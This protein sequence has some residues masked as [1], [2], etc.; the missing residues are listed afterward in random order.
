MTLENIEPVFI[1][2]LLV[3]IVTISMVLILLLYYYHT[4]KQRKYDEK[5][6]RAEL[7]M[8]RHELEKQIYQVTNRLLATEERWKDIHHLLISAQNKMLSEDQREYSV[9]LTEFLKAAGIKE[10][11]LMIKKDRVLVLTPFHQDFDDTYEVITSVCRDVGLTCFRGDEQY[12][13]SDILP[14]ILKLMVQARIII[15]NI[16]GR[17]PNVSYELGLAHAIDKPTIL[18]TKGIGN[19]RGAVELPI[20]LKSRKI[21]LYQNHSDLAEALRA[22]ITRVLVSLE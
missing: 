8:L 4:A 21:I 17:N 3:V 10:Q 2:T 18:L 1:I 15:A 16:E 6:H 9:H 7:S 12:I 5:E 13:L 19:L 22:E 11:D 14:H 20:D